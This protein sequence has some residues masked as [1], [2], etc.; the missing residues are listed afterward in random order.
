MKRILAGVILILISASLACSLGQPSK[1]IPVSPTPIPFTE[2][3]LATAIPSP[4]K[5]D[6]TKVQGSVAGK[7]LWA[8]HS[9]SDSETADPDFAN[10]AP[11]VGDCS[12]P[13]QPTWAPRPGNRI[14]TLTLT[15]AT[16][17][18]A[19]QVDIFFLGDAMG[20]LRVEVQNSLSGL[21]QLIYTGEQ[22]SALP[23]SLCPAQLSLPVA[24]DFE[25]DIIII[26]I[27]ADAK[28]LQID[29][30]G[31]T[32]ELFGFVDVPVF[33]RVPLPGTPRGLASAPGG[34]VYVA[35]EPNG[36]YMYDVEGNQLKK[37]PVP[38]ESILSDVAIDAFANL[39]VIDETYGW[40]IVFSPEGIQLTSGGQNLSGKAAVNPQ[41]GN[42]YLLTGYDIQV[43]NT[44]TAE[45]IR[46][47]P[48]N[49][50]H[51]YVSLSFAPDGRLF[52]LRDHDWFP[53]LCQLDPQTGTEL[54]AIPLV[55]SSVGETVARDLAID[56]A[57]N[58]Y[59]LFDINPD[60]TA[61]YMLDRKGS[62]VR[63]FG[64]LATGM[65]DWI[66]GSL[67]ASREITVS[68]DGRFILIADGFGDTSY[69]TAFLVEER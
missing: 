53:T 52:T 49:A 41:D 59:I 38:S 15:Y 21:G 48:L 26:T 32:G 11:D 63:R 29:A 4:S 30:V 67:F 16:P 1:A 57:G 68:P 61:I 24:V 65:D 31:I 10:G 8:V 42:L 37:I 54:D 44:D 60:Q 69:L 13:M 33:W 50:L 9:F 18:R 51:G 40:L 34:L 43:Y 46:Q 19:S 39:F 14:E 17:M 58:I 3:P 5:P 28:P 66:E 35:T 20:F 27:S 64:R 55:R 62:L 23:E 12:E 56:V 2:L 47:I 7:Q 25:I 36:L 6:S 45:F 22:F